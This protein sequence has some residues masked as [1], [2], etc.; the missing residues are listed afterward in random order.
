MHICLYGLMYA[1]MYDLENAYVFFYLCLCVRVCVC[2]Q[3]TGSH[4]HPG[5]Q[6]LGFGPSQPGQE[7]VGPGCG[8][9][10]PCVFQPQQARG[11]TYTPAPPGS[12]RSAMHGSDV[13]FKNRK[14]PF[15]LKQTE[16]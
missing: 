10:M 16:L 6:D 13:M 15:H 3:V 2:M 1:F 5:W 12:T 7:A 8:V 9:R 4:Q 11:E 14:W